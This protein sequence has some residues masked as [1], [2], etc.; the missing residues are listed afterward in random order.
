MQGLTRIA[1]NP[2]T[3][4]MTPAGFDR[5]AAPPVRQIYGQ[6]RDAG[7]A[8]VHAEVPDGMAT[9]DY[10]QL[11]AETR[12][13]PAP[14]YFQHPFADSSGI[15]AAVRNAKRVA[16][17]HA[18]LGLDRIF[19]A[20][21]VSARPRLAAPGQGADYDEG[22]L[23]TLTENLATVA[24]A[25][26]AEG[27]TPCLHQHVGTWIE[28]EH[29][30][31]AV[32]AAIGAATLMLGPDTGHLAWAG[33]D[34]VAFIGRHLDRVGA[35]HLKDIRQGARDR[36]ASS[37][38][39]YRESVALHVF[40]EPGRGDVNLPAVL[41]LLRDFG[42]WAVIEVDLADQPTPQETARISAAWA[43]AAFGSAGE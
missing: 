38:A 9:E 10:R 1:F 43:H 13:A 26:V 12:L 14:G 41:S 39:N 42:G 27:V 29:E 17:Q 15:T 34:P 40:T 35:V 11:L 8:A 25:M 31:E 4:Y 28:T 20:D 19:I 32:L 3:W 5:D 23:A 7:F 24:A 21:E 2:L 6:V 30:T 33:A 16:G 22:R 18:E 37:G 36:A